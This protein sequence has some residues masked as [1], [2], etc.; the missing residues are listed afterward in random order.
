MDKVEMEGV[1]RDYVDSHWDNDLLR[2]EHLPAL[3]EYALHSHFLSV[4]ELEIFQLAI[5]EFPRRLPE[6]VQLLLVEV[7]GIDVRSALANRQ[8]V[9][10]ETVT[11]MGLEDLYRASR[12]DE[13]EAGVFRSP[14]LPLWLAG[15]A[16]RMST[17]PVYAD[18]DTGG[19][20]SFHLGKNPNLPLVARAKLTQPGSAPRSWSGW[21][22]AKYED[23]TRP[24]ASAIAEQVEAQFPDLVGLPLN[25]MVDVLRHLPLPVEAWGE[26]PEEYVDTC[27]EFEISGYEEEDWSL[28]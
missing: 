12:G 6:E 1:L 10:V 9:T 26:I 11:L 27:S 19:I 15:V 25:M 8:D 7:D 18:S 20:I 2:T 21:V 16:F 4:R 3:V 17:A 24:L 23:G 13:V 5:A 22:G 28:L 14:A